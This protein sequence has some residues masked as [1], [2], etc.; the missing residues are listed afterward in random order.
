MT[1]F[2]CLGGHREDALL[3]AVAGV[4]QASEHP[5]ARAVSEA[6][7]ERGLSV[8]QV[9]A[10]EAKPGQGVIGQTGLGSLAIGNMALMRTLCVGFSD[11]GAQINQLQARGKT[12]MLAAVN[13]EPAGIIA[14]EDPIRHSARMMVRDLSD[15]RLV[16]ATGDS[17][18]TAGHVANELGLEQ[19][20]ADLDPAGK[21]ALIGRLQAQGH[22]VAM[23]GDG[24]NDAPALAAADI[25]IAMGCGADVALETAGI[26]LLKG[27]LR[28]V[29]RAR[30]LAV[31]AMRNIR[32]NLFL[33]FAY[34]SACIPLAAG[35][36]YPLFGVLL[37][38]I[39]AAAA[40]SLSSVSVIGNAL[41]LHR[42]KLG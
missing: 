35:L 10:F 30:R 29:G 8:Q 1:D 5:L 26:T 28:A 40:M 37:P 27:D 19:V 33:A 34:N 20:H 12:V 2:I 32:Q 3:S 7:E 14:V 36:L 41:R 31:G 9:D 39:A 18:V 13:R 21:A 15:I 16:M 11:C 4:E 38:P 6:A 25:G 24:I 22:C 17:R 42:L 23:A